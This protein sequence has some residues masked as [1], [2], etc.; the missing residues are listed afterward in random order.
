MPRGG[1]SVLGEVL[2]QGA[3]GRLVGMPRPETRFVFAAGP[4]ICCRRAN[5]LMEIVT[6]TL[7][8]LYALGVQ[9]C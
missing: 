9:L 3:L 2:P 7:R 6:R 1:G 4:G 5:Y 8:G